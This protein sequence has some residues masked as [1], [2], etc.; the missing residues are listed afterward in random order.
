MMYPIYFLH[1]THSTILR[2]VS[3]LS[4]WNS[5]PAPTIIF[6]F[7]SLLP[8]IKYLAVLKYIL[9]R[10]YYN[11]VQFFAM[12]GSVISDHFT[13]NLAYVF[14]VFRAADSQCIF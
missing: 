12:T 8:S 3:Y 6:V 14:L 1:G 10:L 5:R 7:F 9:H 4:I 11:Q 2:N 13:M